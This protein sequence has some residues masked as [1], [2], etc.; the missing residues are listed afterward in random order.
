MQGTTKMKRGA[1]CWRSFRIPV[2]VILQLDNK[3]YVT[4]LQWASVVMMAEVDKVA[5]P[6]DTTVLWKFLGASKSALVIRPVYNFEFKLV[7]A[8]W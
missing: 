2:G 8:E 7:P 3:H 4:L 1:D 6:G 5:G